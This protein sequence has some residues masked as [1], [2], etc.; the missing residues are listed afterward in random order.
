MYGFHVHLRIEYLK[1]KVEFQKSIDDL[2]SK[3]SESKNWTWNKY[4]EHNCKML[5]KVTNEDCVLCMLVKP[6]AVTDVEWEVTN[7]LGNFYLDL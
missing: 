4:V 7:F 2:A 6:S 1:W 3:I 5:H